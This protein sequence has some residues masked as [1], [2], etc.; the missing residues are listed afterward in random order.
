MPVVMFAILSSYQVRGH[1]LSSLIV[2]PPVL[3]VSRRRLQSVINDPQG[4]RHNGVQTG[5]VFKA[6]GVDFV[7]VLRV[8]RPGRKQAARRHDLQIFGFVCRTAS[9]SI[10]KPMQPRNRSCAKEAQARRI[11]IPA[12]H[13]TARS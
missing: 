8:G 6:F 12:G 10:S 3:Q 1:P 11:P 4:F 13:F 5:L 9:N 7:G 2:D